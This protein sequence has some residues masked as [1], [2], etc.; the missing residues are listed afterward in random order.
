ML[1]TPHRAAI[2]RALPGLPV[3][4]LAFCLAFVGSSAHSSEGDGAQG[5][6]P[7][8]AW[9]RPDL[10][11]FFDIASLTPFER[12]PKY[13]DRL[14]LTIEEAQAIE[15]Q[16]ATMMKFLNRPSNPD[17]E[18]PPAGGD[19]SPGAAGAVRGCR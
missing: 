16:A 12:D 2:A 1:P 3:V 15:Q 18:A 17:R 5:D 4:V 8:T 6:I 11:G 7:R 10:S 14:E 13:G 19:G 9:G